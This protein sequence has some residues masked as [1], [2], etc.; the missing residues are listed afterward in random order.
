MTMGCQLAASVVAIRQHIV[1]GA[2]GMVEPALGHLGDRHVVDLDKERKPMMVSSLPVV[3]C[4]GH[5]ARPLVNA[6]LLYL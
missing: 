3:L 1:E 4:S 5:R 2:V 6:G